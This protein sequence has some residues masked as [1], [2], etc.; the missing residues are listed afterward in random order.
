MLLRCIHAETIKLRRSMIFAI[1]I[2]IPIIPAIMGTFN[3]LQN[4]EILQS[5]WY[6]LWT[7]FTLFYASLFFAPLIG[8]YCSYLW[9]MEHLNRNWNMLM[10]AP[11]SVSSMYLGKLA[12]ILRVT[13]VTQMWVGILFFL[14]GKLAGL[15]GVFTP[16]I[17]FWLF[18]G[19][20]A[21]VA[22]GALQLLL[23]M[24]IRSF[25]VPIA[26][27]L[28][29]SVAGLMLS[30]QGL[31]LYFP[32]SLMLMGMNANKSTDAL[33]GSGLSFLVSVCFFFF[34]FYGVAIYILKRRDVRA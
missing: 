10:S 15:P 12:V 34:F 13:V 16:R 18:R 3:Y 14:C 25:S 24:V 26:V 7:Q 28:V 6:S 20:L 32:Y 22:I 9:R 31:G 19:A 27:S 8:I 5:E 23:S 30:N 29:G 11:V 1:C 17:L 2:L 33:S 21:A 4:L